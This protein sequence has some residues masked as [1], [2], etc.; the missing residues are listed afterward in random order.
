M[1]VLGTV[2][3]LTN[4]FFWLSHSERILHLRDKIIVYLSFLQ[5]FKARAAFSGSPTNYNRRNALRI[6]QKQWD[7]SLSLS[8][9]ALSCSDV[10]LTMHDLGAKL[11]WCR[12]HHTWPW[13]FGVRFISYSGD[14]RLASSCLLEGADGTSDSEGS[15][16]VQPSLL[17][18]LLYPKAAES[19]FGPPELCTEVWCMIHR[20]PQGGIPRNTLGNIHKAIPSSR[21]EKLRDPEICW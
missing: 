13:S 5:C 7:R 15:I 20:P 17:G 8:S 9:L 6:W 21:K 11:Q 19:W 12:T 18:R 3:W 14:N 4:T 2:W 16:L 1:V 10:G